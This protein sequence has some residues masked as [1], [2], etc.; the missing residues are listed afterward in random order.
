MNKPEFD[1][2]VIGGGSAGLVVAAGGASLGAKV[3]LVEKHLLGGDCLN[4]GCVPSKAL[5]HSA[6]VAH[7]MHNAGR[8]GIEPANPYINI[9]NVMQRVRN[10]IKTIEVHDSPERFRGMGIDVV[11]GSGRFTSSDT[12]QVNDRTITAKHFVIATGSR[13]AIPGIVGIDKVPCLTNETVFSIN[14]QIP[15]L[16]VLGGGPIGIEMTQAF[17]RLGSRVQVVELGNRILPREDADLAEVVAK[18][19]QQEGVTFHLGH[20]AQGVTHTDGKIYLVLKAPD[21]QQAKIEGSHLLIAVGRQSNIEGLGLEVADVQTER[22]RIVTDQRLRT[23][24]KRIFACGDVVG[25]YLF[26]H[27]AEHHAGIVLR[28]AI[29]RLPTK[30]EE[31]VIPWCTFS[32]PELARVG[33]SETEAQRQGIPHKVYKFPFKDIDRAQTEGA[34]EGFAKIITDPKGR[35]LGAALV[36]PNAGE[37]IHEYVL[38]IAKRMKTSDLSGIIHIYP[39]LSQINRRVADARM[40]EGLTPMAKK[41]IKL[42]FGLRG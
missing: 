41:W 9:T 33:L 19:L 38:A 18:Q 1:I 37:L 42:I 2:C 26:T 15:D 40:K 7:T 32:D 6:K 28:N 25:P 22:G 34:T 10:V 29:F 16:I 30:I 8:Y 12:F 27:M 31:R 3:V 35:L 36:G 23:T 14:E 39:T 21:G 24:N 4:Y 5:L 11:F 13:P 20:G 17:C